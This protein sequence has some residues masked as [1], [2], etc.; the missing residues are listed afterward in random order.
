MTQEKLCL[1]PGL[2]VEESKKFVRQFDSL[3]KT[4][5]LARQWFRCAGCSRAIGGIFGQANY[6]SFTGGQYCEECFTGKTAVIPIRVIKNWDFTPRPVS[7][8][9]EIFLTAMW[10]EPILN[11]RACFTKDILTFAPDIMEIIR[12]R[13]ER[14]FMS[15]YMKTCRDPNVLYKFARWLWPRSYLFID[16]L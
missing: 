15:R 12:T 13:K 4:M 10:P 1:A 8:K 7:D 2:T 14:M 5:G 16:I 6:C 3:P 9:A 11:S